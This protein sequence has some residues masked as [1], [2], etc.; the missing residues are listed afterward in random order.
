[1][2]LRGIAT[3]PWGAY[4]HRGQI[5]RLKRQ[6]DQMFDDFSARDAWQRAG[7][8][9]LI[10]VTEDAD[11]YYLRA[12]L[13]GVKNE[14]LDIQATGK[15]ISIAGERKIETKNEKAKFHRREREAGK[16][17]RMFS[18]KD[19][20]DPEKVTANMKDGILLLT[21]PKAEVAKPRQIKIS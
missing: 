4:G 20:I 11:N 12:E 18:L 5:D 6:L 8:F 2:F 14:D 13:P 9:P 10:N 15:N 16:F 17:S 19:E 7:V 21:L 1:M 3:S